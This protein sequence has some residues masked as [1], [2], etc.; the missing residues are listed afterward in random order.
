MKPSRLSP[1]MSVA[2]V[3]E[4]WPELIP[5]FLEHRMACVGC[6]MAAFETLQDAARIYSLHPARFLEELETS[7][8]PED[9]SEG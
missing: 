3:L 9:P 5:T 1:Q 6:S 2:D 8:P 4:R 7:L